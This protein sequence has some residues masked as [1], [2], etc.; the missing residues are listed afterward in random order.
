MNE[1][2]IDQIQTRLNAVKQTL[3]LIKQ[4]KYITKGT[5]YIHT[6]WELT[7]ATEKK[8]IILQSK[9]G[10]GLHVNIIQRAYIIT[11][12]TL[13]W[14]AIIEEICAVVDRVLAVN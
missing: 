8:N 12:T 7:L 4:F 3:K 1:S 9:T 10:A 11:D 5:H 13:L 2:T 6:S 14:K